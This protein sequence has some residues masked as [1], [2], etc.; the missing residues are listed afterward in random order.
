MRTFKTAI[1]TPTHTVFDGAVTLVSLPATEGRM[2]IMAHHAPLMTSLKEGILSVTN[3]S[4]EKRT[5]SIE[6]GFA[7]VHHNQCTVLVEKMV[8]I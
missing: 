4:G 5:W 6:G 7:E 1:I 3:E 2:G 8:S